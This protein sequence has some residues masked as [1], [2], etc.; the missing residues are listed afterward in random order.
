MKVSDVKSL[1]ELEEENYRLKQMYADLSLKAQMQEKV[2]KSYST[3]SQVQSLATKITGAVCT[4]ADN[5]GEF[6]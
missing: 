5:G 3:C 1:K 6:K 2:I 4:S